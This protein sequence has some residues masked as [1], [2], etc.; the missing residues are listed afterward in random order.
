M[1]SDLFEVNRNSILKGTQLQ[2]SLEIGI[3]TDSEISL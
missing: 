3:K 1:A 2:A